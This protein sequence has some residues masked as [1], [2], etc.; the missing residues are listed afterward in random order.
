MNLK[1]ARG[2]MRQL[3]KEVMPEVLTAELKSAIYAELKEFINA[4]LT[5]IH[6]DVEATMAEI[7]QRS[8]DAQDYL[9]RNVQ[10]P[11]APMAAPVAETSTT[12]EANAKSAS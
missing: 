7:N 12:D 10:A 1:Q 8:K 5:A 4:R 6:K 2:Q 3:V 11:I 9:V